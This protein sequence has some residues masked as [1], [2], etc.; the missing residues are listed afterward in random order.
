MHSSTG[1]SLAGL[2]GM[3]VKCHAY[4]LRLSTQPRQSRPR[5][6]ADGGLT[7]LPTPTPS[8]QSF[9]ICPNHRGVC[10]DLTLPLRVRL[11]AVVNDIHLS[12]TNTM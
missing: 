5:H 6:V 10:S 2:I 12:L 1:Q 11:L 8:S 3:Q 9:I 4:F 7:R